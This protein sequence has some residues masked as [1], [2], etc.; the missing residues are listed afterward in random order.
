MCICIPPSK[1]Q[2][3]HKP[4]ARHNIHT[5][6][7]SR[8]PFGNVTCVRAKGVVR[9][10]KLPLGGVLVLLSLSRHLRFG[11]NTAYSAR[12]R[13]GI[14]RGRNGRIMDESTQKRSDD[15]KIRQMTA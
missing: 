12:L 9:K 11:P 6:M 13:V 8:K 3:R 14:C 7:G 4:N 2:R 10:L 15:T 5:R 1:T